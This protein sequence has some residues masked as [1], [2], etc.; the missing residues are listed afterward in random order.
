MLKVMDGVYEKLDILNTLPNEMRYRYTKENV[1][2][3]LELGHI[4]VRE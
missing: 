1:Q 3:L 2:K 4:D